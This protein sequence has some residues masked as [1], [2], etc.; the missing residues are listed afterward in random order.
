VK[1]AYQN[2]ERLLIAH[3]LRDV[4]LTYKVQELMGGHSFNIDEH[5]A[6]ITYLYGFYESGHDPDVSTFLSYVDDQKLR[7][8]LVEIGMLSIEE[9]ISEQE[10]FDYI[11]QVL[12]HQKMLKIKEKETELKDAER[13]HDFNQAKALLAEIIQLRKTL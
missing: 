5:Q 4:D 6:I 8:I 12:K 7:R 11:N 2:A 3:M 10:L 1:P 9:E 13:H